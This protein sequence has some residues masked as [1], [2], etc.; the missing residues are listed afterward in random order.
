[1]NGFKELDRETAL[2]YLGEPY[3]QDDRSLLAF[4]D[5]VLGF[6]RDWGRSF[7][8]RETSDPYE[9]LLS[10]VMLQQ[11]Q[12][13]RAEPKYRR[14]LELWPTFEDLAAA[15]LADLLYEW[16]GLGYNRRALY[17]SRAAKMT[18]Q[19]GWTVPDDP[20]AIRSLPGVGKSTTAAILCFCYNERA[21]YLETNVRRVLLTCFFPDE[22][23]VKDR[24]LEALLARLALLNDDLKSWYYALM[25][26]GVLLKELLPNANTRSAHYARQSRFENSNRQI[27]GLLI[28]ILTESGPKRTD[29]LLPLLSAFSGERV[30]RCLGQLEQEGFVEET[31][32]GYA[33]RRD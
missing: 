6:Y 20:V 12:T 30:T 22:T 31:E 16:K 27:R 26:Y 3:G 7:P 25:D 33:I 29:D 9:V 18:G 17:L 8:W 1:M 24:T 21:V 5:H 13:F 15:P 10:E 4:R 14:F 11:T 23:G 2:T 19:W 32:A 28:H